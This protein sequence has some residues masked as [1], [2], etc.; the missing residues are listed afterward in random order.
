MDS[1]LH[2]K[3]LRRQTKYAG[4]IHGIWDQAVTR[5]GALALAADG[6]LR[7]NTLCFVCG[8]QRAHEAM[9]LSDP[10]YE[11]GVL[12]RV[13]ADGRTDGS[14]PMETNRSP[15]AWKLDRVSLIIWQG[16]LPENVGFRLAGLCVLRRRRALPSSPWE[17]G[18]SNP[19]CRSTVE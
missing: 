15:S 9:V 17:T 12:A 14:L 10:S 3:S 6:N 13:R 5:D 7:N 11:A 8:E 18:S 16:T 1:D 4:G 19:F 2:S